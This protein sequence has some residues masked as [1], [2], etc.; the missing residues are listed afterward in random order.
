MTRKSKNTSGI[1]KS[2]SLFDHVNHIK[3]IQDPEYYINLSDSDKKSFT[4]YMILRV[5]SMS[6]NDIGIIS[7]ISKYLDILSNENL[8]LLLIQ[9]IEKNNKFDKYIKSTSNKVNSEVVNCLCKKFNVGTRDVE[10]YISILYST[11]KLNELSS[12]LQ[13]FGYNDKEI[14]KLIKI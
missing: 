11:G 6:E 5:L 2:K 7:Y 10:D 12:I 14:K 1:I 9:V 3:K 8:Y 4:S 13:E